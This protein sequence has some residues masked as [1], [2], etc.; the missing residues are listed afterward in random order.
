MQAEI[1]QPQPGE[2]ETKKDSEIITINGVRIALIDPPPRAPEG[3]ERYKVEFVEIEEGY[4]VPKEI[5]IDSKDITVYNVRD[6][7]HQELI[8]RDYADHKTG[9]GYVYGLYGIMRYQ[10]T[11]RSLQHFDQYRAFFDAKEGRQDDDKLPMYMQPRMMPLPIDINKIHPD[12]RTLFS[13]REHIENFYRIAGAIH[14]IAPLKDETPYLHPVFKTE[15][16]LAAE[17]PNLQGVPIEFTTGAFFWFDDPDGR[18]ISNRIISMNPWSTM[19]VSSFNEHGQDPIWKFDEFLGD[20]AGRR[21]VPFDMIVRDPLGEAAGITS[22]F[23]QVVLPQVDD[24]EPA[25]WVVRKGPLDLSQD[26]QVVTEWDD[27]FGTDIRIE[28]APN[29]KWA[30]SAH[31][32]DDSKSKLAFNKQEEVNWLKQAMQDSYEERHPPGLLRRNW[33]YLRQQ[34]PGAY[35]IG[36]RA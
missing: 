1:L 28:E 29:C 27:Y 24:P 5:T 22:S 34:F 16:E 23:D 3:V 2:L 10:R 31:P 20:F 4:P 35:N 36:L 21:K 15:P 8:A 9:V 14:V 17:R 13:S 6:N 7:A 19:A 32:H 33:L 11:P 26:G 25:L 30:S 12:Y 18:H